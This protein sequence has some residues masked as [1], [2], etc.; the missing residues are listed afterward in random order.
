MR[1]AEIAEQTLRNFNKKSTNVNEEKEG[2]GGKTF[3]NKRNSKSSMVQ[4]IS[5]GDGEYEDKEFWEQ[6]VYRPITPEIDEEALAVFDM[7][8]QK[9]VSLIDNKNQRV[10]LSKESKPVN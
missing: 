8:T 5:T 2:G 4:G 3:N 10:F 9:I 1:A 7:N 6:K